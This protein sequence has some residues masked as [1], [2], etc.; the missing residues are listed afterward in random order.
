MKTA[1]ARW[2]ASTALALVSVAA[3]GHAT[4]GTAP[5][6]RWAPAIEQADA[7]LARKEYTAALRSANEAYARALGATRWDGMI[8]VG[9]LYRRMGAATGL[10]ASF[11]A[12]AR[13]AYRTALFR[14]RQQASVDGVLRA[15]E[16]YA[17]L[18]DEETVALGLRVAERLAAGDAETL[19][20]VR[21]LRARLGD[22]SLA[23]RGPRR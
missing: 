9:D 13:E 16:G 12:K 18:G 8:S 3:G 10:R 11:D 19:A 21:V 5:G 23:A 6:D 20:A 17:A 7:A 1:A 15:T 14:A 22:P 4:A 2:V